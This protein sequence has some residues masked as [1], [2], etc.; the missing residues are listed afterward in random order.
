MRH[1][2]YVG[3]KG[4]LKERYCMKTMHIREENF[5]MDLREIS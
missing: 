3:E 5:K 1:A 2:A 4:D